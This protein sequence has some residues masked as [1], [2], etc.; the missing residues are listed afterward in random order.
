MLIKYLGEHLLSVASELTK[1]KTCRSFDDPLKRLIVGQVPHIF[2]YIKYNTFTGLVAKVINVLAT[3]MWSYTDLFVMIL[4]V[5]LSSLFKQ[6]NESL[7]SNE[8][9]I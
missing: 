2:A 5:G 9:N 7:I 4:S 3:F 8:V 1:Q 6:I